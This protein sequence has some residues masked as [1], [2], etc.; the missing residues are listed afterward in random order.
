MITLTG[1]NGNKHYLAPSA[2]ASVTEAGVSSQWHGIRAYVK[3]FDGQ[4]IEVR[5]EAADIA[6]ELNMRRAE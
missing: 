3:T 2:V 5:E 1:T 4:M 6:R